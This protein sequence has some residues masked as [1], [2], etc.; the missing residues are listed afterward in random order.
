MPELTFFLDDETDRRVRDAARAAGLSCGQWLTYLVRVETR[1]AWSVAARCLAGSIPEF[2]LGADFDRCS[3]G[4]LS[5]ERL[6]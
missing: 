3:G 6:Q 1:E 2:P 5:R 4:D